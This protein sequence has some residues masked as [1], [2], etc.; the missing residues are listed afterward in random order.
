MTRCQVE[1]DKLAAV[2]PVKNPWWQLT[3]TPIRGFIVGGGWLLFVAA[4]TAALIL[5]PGMWL[6]VQVFIGTALAFSYLMSAVML[7]R[8]QRSA[9]IES[10][11]GPFTGK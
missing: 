1:G 4:S 10:C 9:R 3:K 2:G 5:K 7:R 11:G 8:R 6:V